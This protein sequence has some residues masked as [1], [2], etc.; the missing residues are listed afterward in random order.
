VKLSEFGEFE[1]HFDA[2][3]HLA[4]GHPMPSNPPMCFVSSEWN[5]N[6]LIFSCAY[7][8]V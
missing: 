2:I 8:M 1:V 3:P 7:W 6:L 4:C 5:C